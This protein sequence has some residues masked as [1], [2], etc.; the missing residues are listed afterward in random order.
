MQSL[1]VTLPSNQFAGSVLCVVFMR[2][3]LRHMS[4]DQEIL[5]NLLE[6]SHE[7]SQSCRSSEYRAVKLGKASTQRGLSD[8]RRNVFKITRTSSVAPVVMS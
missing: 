6:V 7:G 2:N 8:E 4:T 3:I 5:V 1:V